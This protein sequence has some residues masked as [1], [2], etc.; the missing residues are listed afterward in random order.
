MT[1]STPSP[2]KKT[3]AA[4][5]KKAVKAPIKATVK[6]KAPVKAAAPVQPAGKA[7]TANAPK[8]EKK[9]DKVE[10]VKVVRDSFTIPK[11][12]YAQIAAMKKRAMDLGLEIKKSELIRA[13]LALLGGAADASFR[14]ALGNVPTLKTGRPGKG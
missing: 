10:K 11:N 1:P 14:K 12:E 9:K 2:K 5:V 4:P 8:I 13:G 6:P 7:T 3:P